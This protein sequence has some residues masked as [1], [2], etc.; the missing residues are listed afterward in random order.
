MNTRASLYDRLGGQPTLDRLAQRFYH[1]MESMPAAAEVHAMHQMSLPQVEARLRA[2]LSG[3]FGGPDI[4]RPQYGEP[5]MRRRHLPFPIGPRQRDAW[6]ACMRKALDEVAPDPALRDESYAQI[7][8]FAEHMRNREDT[9]PALR[10]VD[11]RG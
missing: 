10:F 5:M 11:V 6:L 3:F 4:Y 8:A 1:W 2:F 7:A 9:H